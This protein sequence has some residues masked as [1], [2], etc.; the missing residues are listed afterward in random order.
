MILP[1]QGM[2]SRTSAATA[3]SLGRG[4]G[5]LVA[6]YKEYEDL[7]VALASPAVRQH[8]EGSEAEKHPGAWGEPPPRWDVTH[9]AVGTDA[10]ARSAE[11]VTEAQEGGVGETALKRWATEAASLILSGGV[12]PTVER[13]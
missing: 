11:P 6:S 12:L 1:G 13:Q 5:P 7:A 9:A 8:V 10:A 3:V 2:C 4:F